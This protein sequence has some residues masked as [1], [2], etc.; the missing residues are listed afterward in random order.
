MTNGLYDAGGV[1]R[2]FPRSGVLRVEA[3]FLDWETP[4]V[5]SALGALLNALAG[6]LFS[7][8]A[9]VQMA[10]GYSAG[11]EKVSAQ[12][13]AIWLGLDVA[14]DAYIGHWKL[15]VNR[16]WS[17]GAKFLLVFRPLPLVRVWWTLRPSRRNLVS[18]CH[19]PDVAFFTL[20]AQMLRFRVKP[21]LSEWLL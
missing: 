5:T 16:R 1:F 2:P 9:L 3:T 4:L 20:G 15:I 7:A 18:G 8:M 21:R 17:P 14:W 19:D 10:V 13:T 12:M 11:T 6:A